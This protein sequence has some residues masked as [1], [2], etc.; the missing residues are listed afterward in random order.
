MASARN[1]AGRPPVLWY[2]KNVGAESPDKKC[3]RCNG[4]AEAYSQRN[5]QLHEILQSAE[6]KLSMIAIPEAVKGVRGL[7]ND[8]KT[9]EPLEKGLLRAKHDVSMFKD[10]TVRFDATNA[11]LTHFKG[12][13][14]GV[15]VEKLQKLGYHF[16]LAGNPLD[17]TINIVT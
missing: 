4:P 6:R 16:D 14:I 3:P 17:Q 11:P 10:G 1:A 5:L 2:A 7:T 9:P 8:T 12:S 13:E 15:D